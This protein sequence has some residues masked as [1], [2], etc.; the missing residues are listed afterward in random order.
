MSHTYKTYR[1]PNQ[2]ANVWGISFESK[3]EFR[4]HVKPSDLLVRD[5]SDH[6]TWIWLE[7]LIGSDVMLIFDL[8]NVWYVFSS[9]IGWFE[10]AEAAEAE[11]V[12]VASAFAHGQTLAVLEQ[13]LGSWSVTRCEINWCE[14]KTDL[15]WWNI[16]KPTVKPF[17][18][19]SKVT[20]IL[21]THIITMNI[22]SAGAI[23]WWIQYAK[24]MIQ[25]GGGVQHKGRWGEECVAGSLRRYANIETICDTP[26][27]FS[28][29]F[30]CH[31]RYHDENLLVLIWK[32]EYTKMWRK[33]R[34]IRFRVTPRAKALSWDPPWLNSPKVTSPSSRISKRTAENETRWRK[35]YLTIAEALPA[36]LPGESLVIAWLGSRW[37]WQWAVWIMFFALELEILLHVTFLALSM[38][39]FRFRFSQDFEMTEPSPVAE[40]A[41]PFMRT[42]AQLKG[43]TVSPALRPALSNQIKFFNFGMWESSLGLLSDSCCTHFLP[44]SSFSQNIARFNWKWTWAGAGPQDENSRV[45][46]HHTAILQSTIAVMLPPNTGKEFISSMNPMLNR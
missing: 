10:A 3:A 40:Y 33:A 29:E 34:S 35:P 7:C 20:A 9:K 27:A 22:E 30:A 45:Q 19:I 2:G 42:P 21:L 46:V 23:W 5:G 1:V 38:N 26:I 13:C 11:A 4:R 37:L 28:D 8:W 16:V 41:A 17:R 12:V 15:T 24:E 39:L 25:G 6:P 18:W 43:S 32:I 44:R 36:F 14:T 31:L